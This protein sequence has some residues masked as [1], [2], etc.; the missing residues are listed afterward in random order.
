LKIT[1]IEPAP[2]GFHVYSFIRQVRLGLPLLG[3]LLSDLGHEVTIFVESLAEVDWRRVAASDLVGISTITSTAM[4]AY[5]YAERA[6]AAGVPVVMGGPHVTFE[7]EEALEFADYVVRGEGEDAILELVGMLEGAVKPEDIRGLSY[8]TPDGRDRHN[9][10]RDLRDSLSDLPLPDL[11]LIEG[12]GKIRPTPFLTSRGCPHDCEFCSVIEMFGRRV[13][14]VAP[15]LVIEGIRE[16]APKSIF[17]YDDNFV[18]S[19]DSAKRLLARM[20]REDLGIPFSAQIRVDSVYKRGRIDREL[21]ELLVEAGCY[22]VYLG[23]ESVNPAT[24]AAY[25][26]RQTVDDIAGGLAA[27]HEYGIRTH[28]MFVFGSD[29]DTVES[30]AATADFAIEHEI[31]S[32]QFMILTPLPGT[33]QFRSL[34]QQG[35]IFTRNWSLYDGHHAVFWPRNMGPLELQEASMEAH[36]RFYRLRRIRSNPKHRFMGFLISYG[37][38]HVPDNMAYLRELRNF[39]EERRSPFEAG[40]HRETGRYPLG[41]S[42]T[43]GTD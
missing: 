14:T 35:R 39:S 1:L 42:A 9:P 6:R 12:H 29:T 3:R 10:P 23:L 32:A 2:P 38:E 15:D 7:A 24:L 27:L 22:L 31:S 13:R 8:R 30:M 34:E 36:M 33:R 21:L 43:A 20:A 17:F 16:A 37:W 26:K 5:R 4:K 28:G 11:S 19:K 18:M 25:N 41:S 40:S